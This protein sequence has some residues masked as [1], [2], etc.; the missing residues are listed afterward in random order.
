MSVFP[1]WFNKISQEELNGYIPLRLTPFED[2]ELRTLNMCADTICR[3]GRLTYEQERD[4][5]R[6]YN[7]IDAINEIGLKRARGRAM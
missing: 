7:R 1:H 4:L 6:I 5:T 3:G 2:L